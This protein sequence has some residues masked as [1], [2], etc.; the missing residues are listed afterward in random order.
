[1]DKVKA[2]L[3]NE[4]IKLF[5]QEGNLRGIGIL[6][7]LR[8]RTQSINCML[9]CARTLL[10]TE[11]DDA[12]AGS[13]ARVLQRARSDN[14][15]VADKADEMVTLRGFNEAFKEEDFDGCFKR[16]QHNPPEGDKP[17]YGIHMFPEAK[18]GDLQ[19]SMVSQVISE[20]ALKETT[21]ENMSCI[22]RFVRAGVVSEAHS[23]TSYLFLQW[24]C[25]YVSVVGRFVLIVVGSSGVTVVKTTNA[26]SLD[27]QGFRFRFYRLE[28]CYQHA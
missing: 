18:A 4:S 20:L 14:L 7:K 22:A 27:Q 19:M 17:N 24:R 21:D 1:M 28:G 15:I 16:L 11:G 12:K 23:I 6:Q 25:Q 2:R 10:A 8:D 26:G 13:L 3:G 5:N 9:D